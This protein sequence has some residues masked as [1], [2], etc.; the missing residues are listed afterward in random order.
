MLNSVVLSCHVILSKSK[1]KNNLKSKIQKFSPRPLSIGEGDTPS[2]SPTPFGAF[3][4]SFASARAYGAR[5]YLPPCP[6]PD[7]ALPC[8]LVQIS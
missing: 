3:G 6:P 4:A 7:P 8:P 5:V 2:P 1:K